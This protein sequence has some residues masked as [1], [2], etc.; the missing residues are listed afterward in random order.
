M[1]P[2]SAAPIHTHLDE[3]STQLAGLTDLFT[4]RLLDDRGYRQL[5]ASLQQR[6]AVAESG[7]ATEYLLPIAL[8]LA[9]VIDRAE[10]SEP[11]PDSPL[12]SLVEEL[13]VILDDCGVRPIGRP[14]ESVDPA[15]HEVRSV[16][17]EPGPTLRVATL[18]QRGYTW[19]GT[20]VRPAWVDAIYADTDHGIANR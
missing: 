12:A 6:V 17:G 4:R 7:L 9:R 18:L 15:V 8:R 1:N 2:D 10:L 3:I 16:R 11:E 13:E 19:R 14:G 20:V 5:V